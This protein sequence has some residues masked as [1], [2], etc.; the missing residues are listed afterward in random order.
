ME[1]AKTK[2]LTVKM[3]EENDYEGSY[4]LLEKKSLAFKA[5]SQQALLS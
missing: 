3:L 1:A 2:V 5:A 4:H